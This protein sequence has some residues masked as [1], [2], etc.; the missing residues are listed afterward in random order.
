M[1]AMSY[2]QLDID[3]PSASREHLIAFLAS[4]GALGF[5]ENETRLTVYFPGTADIHSL[6]RELEL[7]NT[8][9]DKAGLLPGAVIS[10]ALLPDQD[11]NESW[12]KGFIPLDVGNRFTIRPPWEEERKGRLNLIIDPGMAFGTGYHETTRSCLILMEKYDNRLA[13]DRFLDLEPAPACSRL[14][15]QNSVTGR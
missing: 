9:L 14:P 10:A 1:T 3:I 8:L 12:K 7:G 5:M 2:Y 4:Q 6:L 15:L 13:K 11:W